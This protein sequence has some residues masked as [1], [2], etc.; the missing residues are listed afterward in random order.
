MDG[1]L[2]TPVS[3]Q[4][5]THWEQFSEY[6]PFIRYW[7]RCWLHIGELKRHGPYKNNLYSNEVYKCKIN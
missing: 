6:Q 1:F 3:F 4:K 5:F 2:Q 7:A